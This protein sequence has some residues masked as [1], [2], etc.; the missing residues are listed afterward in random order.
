MY[1]NTKGER[2]NT[3]QINALSTE[4]KGLRSPPAGGYAIAAAAP[5]VTTSKPSSF[6][7]CI[8]SFCSG[9]KW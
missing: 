4:W 5:P 6:L 3:S 7:K 8:F 2:G 9:R 1:A